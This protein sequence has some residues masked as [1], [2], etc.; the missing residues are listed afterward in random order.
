MTMSGIVLYPHQVEAVERI[1]DVFRT[2]QS[3]LL[4]DAPRVGKTYTALEVAKRSGFEKVL[5]L[6][7]SSIELQWQRQAE[8]YG[9]APTVLSYDKF[10]KRYKKFIRE[11]YDFLILD[12]A[13]Y[14]KNS[15]TKRYKAV[16][17]F[18]V[19]Q[20]RIKILAL[21]GTPFQNGPIEFQNLLVIL[22]RGKFPLVGYVSSYT[23]VI[24]KKKTITRYL[25]VLDKLEELGQKLKQQHWYLRRVFAD[26][27]PYVPRLLRN[28]VPLSSDEFSKE[29]EKIDFMIM[30]EIYKAREAGSW[31]RVK[32]LEEILSKDFTISSLASSWAEL[33]MVR[34]FIGILKTKQ[35]IQYV[36]DLFEIDKERLILFAHHKEV[37]SNIESALK[38]AGL[39]V[40]KITG[41]DR[42]DT[43]QNKI[44]R[45]QQHKIDVLILSTRAMNVGVT[46]DQATRVVFAELDWNPAVLAQAE[47]RAISFNTEQQ[48][49]VD[50]LV[51]D[52]WLENKFIKLLTDKSHAAV[53]I[54]AQEHELPFTHQTKRKYE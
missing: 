34:R 31:Y 50:Y 13:H 52:F 16:A 28:V 20:K 2:E 23:Y 11:Q 53:K 22:R 36:L 9:L 48:M 21:T 49:I 25:W 5:V 15:G 10:A 19:T 39:T 4:A 47:N 51:L 26:V 29:L 35:V 12:E 27:A 30:D 14:L 38:E 32:R 3:F 40:E 33:A 6:C 1:L 24:G 18:L 46:L 43:R 8:L 7:P 45:F 54:Y 37:V 44:D 17:G 41:E 42:S